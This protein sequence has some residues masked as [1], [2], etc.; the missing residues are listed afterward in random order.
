MSKRKK[1][2]GGWGTEANP[3]RGKEIGGKKD[4]FTIIK[5][6]PPRNQGKGRKSCARKKGNERE[7]NKKGGKKSLNEW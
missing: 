6:V 7:A 3:L 1:R 4:A 5:R 2:H